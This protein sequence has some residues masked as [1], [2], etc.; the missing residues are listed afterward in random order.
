MSNLGTESMKWKWRKIDCA[1][2]F[3]GYQPNCDKSGFKLSDFSICVCTNQSEVQPT[4]RFVQPPWLKQ[5]VSHRTAH[6]VSYCTSHNWTLS[7]KGTTGPNFKFFIYTID[8]KLLFVC[9]QPG[10]FYTRHKNVHRRSL[11][12][13]WQ[14][15]GMQ[16]LQVMNVSKLKFS[17]H[18][19]MNLCSKLKRNF[20][21]FLNK[22]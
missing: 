12:C 10:Q 2:S 14:I 15:S 6:F 9:A 13:L 20:L 8:A 21:R 16:I 22:S 17:I 19:R 4:M 5:H 1:K 11:R 3:T 18:A 7:K